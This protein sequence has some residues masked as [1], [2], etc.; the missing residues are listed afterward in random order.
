[1]KTSY[2]LLATEFRFRYPT[3]VERFKAIMAQ[4]EIN[5]DYIDT[6]NIW[7]RDFMP[8]QTST[9]LVQF[10]YKGYGAGGFKEY[11]WLKLSTETKKQI[12]ERLE[13]R[14]RSIR[15]SLIR[16]DGGNV[17]FTPDKK[18]AVLTDIVFRHNP[19]IRRNRL[20]DRL[21]NLL[22]AEILIVPTEPGDDIGHT[23][24][25]LVFT[26]YHRGGSIHSRCHTYY[27]CLLN[28]YRRK[29]TVAYCKYADKIEKI[30]S[31]R[32]IEFT[33][34]PYAYHRCPRMTEQLFRRQYPRADSFN[35][36]FGYYINLL[37]FGTAVMIP[38]FSLEEDSEAFAVAQP[39]FRGRILY[40]MD[41]RRLS[42]EGGLINCVTAT[43][44]FD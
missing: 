25:C 2:L 16:L 14:N 39:W 29:G 15:H 20:L 35:P 32:G 5:W 28:D 40:G 37:A 19:E 30:L 1:M 17:T 24:G 33:L 22:S 13:S 27:H 31:N 41:C 11:P 21:S 9:G 44:V 12:S 3:L 10:N 36:G 23:D 8:V 6:R 43:Y 26:P 18:L 42:M 7:M 4:H 34:F 38:S